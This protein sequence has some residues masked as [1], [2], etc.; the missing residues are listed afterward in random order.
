MKVTM[1][2]GRPAAGKSFLFRELLDRLAPTT[3]HK[4]P[5]V[6]WHQAN[7]GTRV[8]GDYGDLTEKFPGTD[9]LSMACQPHVIRLL[10]NWKNAGVNAVFFEGDRLGNDSMIKA[11]QYMGVDLEVIHLHSGYLLPRQMERTQP[12]RFLESRRTKIHNMIGP[13]GR[14]ARTGMKA[15]L[16]IHDVPSETAFH[17]SY[18]LKERR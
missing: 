2:I 4:I 5:Y 18:L 10:Q 16:L 8:L 11:L 15:K 7:D 13:E 1:V 3:R 12:S 17:V 6:V 9:R 14:L